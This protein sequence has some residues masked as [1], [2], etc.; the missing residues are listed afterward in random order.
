MNRQIE[1]LKDRKIKIQKDREKDRK[2]DRNIER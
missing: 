2:I 1:I